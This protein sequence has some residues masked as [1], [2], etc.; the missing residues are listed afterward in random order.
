MKSRHHPVEEKISPES[1]QVNSTALVARTNPL[2]DTTAENDEK[3]L[4]SAFIETP[5]FRTLVESD[6][7]TVV[8]GRRGTGKS[9][10]FINLK[11]HW[12]KDKKVITLTFSPEDTEIIGFR[13]LL[14]P[15]SNSFILSRAAT[16][17]LWRYAMLMEVATYI[18]RHY[19]HAELVAKEEVLR[20]HVA[21]WSDSQAPFL[22]KC[23]RIAKAFLSVDSPEEA[24]G[25]LPFNLNLSAVEEHVLKI[26][27]KTDRHVVILMD[28]L[29]EGYESDA[30]GIGIIAG[31]A[32][33]AVE[34]NQKSKLIRPIIFLRDNVFRA[35]AK[36]DPDYSRNL[37]GQ[38]IRLHWD[39]PL[40]LQLAATRMK[41]SFHVEVEK[42]Q[43]VWDRCTAGELQGREGFKRCL[44]FT[45]YRPRDLLSLLNESFFC[46]FRHGR[47]TAIID[48]L[49]YAAKSISVAR[50]E[51]LWKEYQKI[52]PPIQSVTSAFK[53]AEPELSVMAALA[54]IEVATESFENSD[55]QASLIEARLLGATGLLQSLYSIGFI[56]LHDQNLSSYSFCHDGRT[57][58]KGFE[59]ADRILVHPCYWLGLNLSRNALSPE[60]AEE[61]NDEYDIKVDSLNPKIRNAKIGQIV[62]HLDKIPLGRE[63]DR[64]FELWC[65]EAL[66]IIF[67]AH[68]LGLQLHPNGA[69]VQRRD[70]VG[71]N[72]GK[73]DFWNRILLDYK[74]RNVVFD[75]KNYQELGPEE[76]RQLQSY[77]T[78]SYGKLGFIINR[79]DSENLTAGR[80]LD[81]TKEMH[82]SHQC[83]II[84]L[85]AKF[86]NK[87]LQ[88]L[89][90]PEKH[91]AID[92]Q[93]WNLLTTYETNYLGLKSTR[94][95]KK[96][97]SVK[98]A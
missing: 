74:S 23:R 77:L 83:L 9:A 72:R 14:K 36:E 39:W 89:R 60:E 17:L 33:A 49:E 43:R 67:A 93:M 30:I 98:R 26:L 94:A 12:A 59:S 57:P 3:M 52:F 29:D 75:A 27:Q 73:S 90:S 15:F 31:L 88:K 76:Y 28:R 96:P 2:G 13:S 63:G 79:D 22:T 92:R 35:L 47:D 18:S 16:K 1:T 68:L 58:D 69:A 7:R 41:L 78:G 6:D 62:S 11:K 40:L 61:I 21:R 8:V 24:I 42:D 51:D 34:L 37:E 54:K 20:E 4:S 50:L 91:D 95:R 5:D 38:V 70:I 87:L 46:S 66:K 86:I 44:Q 25:D 55:D 97:A 45:L 82:T 65:L 84:K 64:D 81:W 48:D 56:G 53:N 10:L 85:P 32:Y 80:D 71:T 19:K